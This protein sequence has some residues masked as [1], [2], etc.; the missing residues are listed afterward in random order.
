MNGLVPQE[1]R[2]LGRGDQ[3][4]VPQAKPGSPP[5]PAP[6][7][8]TPEQQ[9]A[10]KNAEVRATIIEQ[11]FFPIAMAS[12]IP[13]GKKV[14]AA[15]FKLYIDRLLGGSGNSGDAIERMLIE[16]IALAHL[17]IA[18]LHVQAATAT[19]P[20]AAKIYATAATRLTGEFRRLVLALR[21]YRQPTPKRSITFVKQ[22]NLVAGGQQVAYVDQSGKSQ[23]QILFT[24]GGSELASNEGL[25]IGVSADSHREVS[26]VT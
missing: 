16:Q 9:A 14:G 19:T 4:L 12:A 24:D 18:E 6:R 7:E 17:R 20:E 1:D 3:P 5:A 25:K 21:Q 22:Q 23:E 15:G 26:P 11:S 8:L 2:A 13:A 10:L